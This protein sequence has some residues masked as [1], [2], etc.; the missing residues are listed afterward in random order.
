M[1]KISTLFLSLGAALVVSAQTQIPNSGFDNWSGTPSAPTGWE[2]WETISG[3]AVSGFAVKDTTPGNFVD[4]TA[5]LKL[6][7]D[8][9][10]VQQTKVLLAGT[11][12]YFGTFTGLPDTLKFAYKY[13]PGAN[14]SAVININTYRYD[15]GTS[16]YVD[17]LDGAVRLAST[18]NNWYSI[19]V[20]LQY[21]GNLSGTPDSIDIV[22]SSSKGLQN[23][24]TKGSVVRFDNLRFVY[25]NTVGIQ[26]AVLSYAGLKFFPNPATTQ[27]T[28]DGSVS[29]VGHELKVISLDGRTVLSS[30]M[31]S[32]TVDVSSLN[33]GYYIFEVNKAGNNM[34]KGKFNISK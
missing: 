26:E 23:N 21:S 20:P 22:L 8:S 12:S 34:L 5:S 30:E 11:A 7:T 18:N 25:A 14:D 31:Y 3:G 1:K 10:L 27:I 19:F 13:A 33:N 29:L 9:A 24:G 28:F 15:A 17:Y 2:T 16:K 6:T 32:N 4:G